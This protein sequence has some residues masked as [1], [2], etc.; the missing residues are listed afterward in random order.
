MNSDG[1]IAVQFPLKVTLSAMS[2]RTTAL[3]EYYIARNKNRYF[4]I[5]SSIEASDAIIIDYDYPGTAT[6]LSA[7]G[8]HD[9]IPLIVLAV[10]DRQIDGAI[11]VRKPLDSAGLESAAASALQQ[12]NEP[13]KRSSQAVQTDVDAV[14]HEKIPS[15]PKLTQKASISAPASS[16]DTTL[17][18]STEL[19]QDVALEA[20][21]PYFRTDDATRKAS[22]SLPIHTRLSRYQ[23]KIE[24]L[25]GAYRSLEQL[26]DPDDPEHRFDAT[27]C[28]ARRIATLT[29]TPEPGLKAAQFSLPEADIYLFPTLGK[30]YTSLSL[31]N[32]RNV[33]RM[34][35][36]AATSE[37]KV[38][39]S[40]QSTVNDVI[41]RLNQSPHYS[42]NVQSFCWL[43]ALFFAQGRLPRGL[44]IN[45]VWKLRHWPNITRLELVPDCLEIAA[46]WSQKPAKLTE[47]I[48]RAGCEPR[49]VTSFFNAVSTIG[50]TY[51][52]DGYGR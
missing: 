33:D 48:E 30:V 46:A 29:A 5:A 1:A 35:R 26:S 12:L 16:A 47:L 43:G 3:I 19:S 21:P 18:G 49:Y 34:F 50:V 9:D 37:I 14:P 2:D 22:S 4:A 52:D 32:S 6:R 40:R 24:Q 28:L 25:C 23:A 8:W 15:P 51:E 44:D 11:M 27:N 38:T 17:A 10:G 7:S 41:N 13:S 31:E 45:T 20:T 39:K 42:F 36:N